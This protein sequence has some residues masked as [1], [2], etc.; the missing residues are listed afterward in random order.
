MY[1]LSIKKS[2]YGFHT[3]QKKKHLENAE[4]AKMRE[5]SNYK[6]A[7]KRRHLISVQAFERKTLN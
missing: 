4:Q 2:S 3:D 6:T 7:F 1:L 5:N